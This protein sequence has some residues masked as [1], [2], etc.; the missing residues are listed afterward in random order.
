MIAAS[1]DAL[2]R[3]NALIPG[4]HYSGVLRPEWESAFEEL[5]EISYRVYRE[6]ILND[7]GILQYFELATPVG[8]LEHAR[9][10]SRPARR[11]RPDELRQSARHPLGLRMDAKPPARARL[12]RRRNSFRRISRASP[13][14]SP[15]CAR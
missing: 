2:A 5:S 14:A 12:V 15:S 11:A 9:I 1:L 4:E 3:P 13:P 8:E 6:H 10:G 7:P